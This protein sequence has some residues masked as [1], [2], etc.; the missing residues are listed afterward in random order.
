VLP[1]SG[2]EVHLSSGL[3]YPRT[4]AYSKLYPI[5]PAIAGAFVPEDTALLNGLGNQAMKRSDPSNPLIDVPVFLGELREGF[6]RVIAS[7]LLRSRLK[8]FR[9]LGSEYLN[10][11]FGWK[12]F[13]S[14]IFGG[15]DA[16][17][18]AI[19][20]IRETKVRGS[21]VSHRRYDYPI[22]R[23]T[24]KTTIA[25]GASLVPVLSSA[26]FLS[27]TGT[28]YRERKLETQR[29]FSGAFRH[30]VPDVLDQ[31]EDQAERLRLLRKEYGLR[32]TPD[33]LWELAPWSWMLDWFINVGDVLAN[34]SNLVSF[35]S[36]LTYGYIMEHVRVHDLYWSEGVVF[37]DGTPY[38]GTLSIVT[39]RKS[40]RKAS[41]FGFGPGY[42]WDGF[43]QKQ[44][45][46][47]AALGISRG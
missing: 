10:V 3:S 2:Q 17:D 14:D 21:K 26:L 12:P 4:T 28:V 39:D 32:L 35:N 38:S 33:A 43:S 45:A 22:T 40:R 18:K 7:G 9:E 23:T 13:L 37:K 34:V 6:P 5:S 19:K 47:L 44:L 27:N 30:Y 41:P 8:D 46:I 11:E 25:T 20:L 24:E 29:W 15:L 36:A 31:Y 1:G 42:V 16:H